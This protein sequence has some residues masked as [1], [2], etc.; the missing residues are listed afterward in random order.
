MD[1]HAAPK[2]APVGL[3]NAEHYRWGEVCDGWHLLKVND[4]SV[5]RERVPPG[6]VEMRHRHMR[7]RQFFYV[8]E[9]A[10]MLEVD[11]VSHA[12]TAG[13]GLHVPPGAAHR[14]G[15]E[16]DADVHFIVVSAPKSHGDRVD[17]QETGA[18]A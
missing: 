3:D 10:A 18:G 17:I 6:G 1:T 12:L 8:L 9:G 13:Q 11:G 7:A 16:S 4:L 2:I 14:F 5:I 15:N